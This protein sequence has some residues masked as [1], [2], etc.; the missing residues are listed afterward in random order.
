M[1]INDIV[2]VHDGSY[3]LHYRGSGELK[4]TYGLSPMSSRRWRV[5]ATGVTLPADHFNKENDTMLCEENAPEHILFTQARFCTLVKC[6]C[7]LP[8]LSK[9]V[10]ITVPL[11]TK[12][13]ILNIPE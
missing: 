3:S 5:L 4:P 10:E 7:A 11:G 6:Y 12:T 1:K 8:K 13:V 9:Q 2:S